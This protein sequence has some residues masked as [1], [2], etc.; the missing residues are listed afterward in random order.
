[1]GYRTGQRV[2]GDSDAAS[3]LLDEQKPSSWTALI[4]GLL[5]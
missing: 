1:L 4:V 3:L 2:R 5:P